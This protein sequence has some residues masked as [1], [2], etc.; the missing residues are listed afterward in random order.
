MPEDGPAAKAGRPPPAAAAQRAALTFWGVRAGIAA[1]GAATAAFG[2]NSPC[3]AVEVFAG[4]EA[5][6][7]VV[8]FDAGTG[9]RPLGARLAPR[10]PVACDLLFGHTGFDRICGLP[11]FAAAFDAANRI[12]CHCAHRPREGG[13]RAALAG[14]MA[15]PL[16]PVPIDV[17]KAAMSF[18]D[19]TPGGRAALFGGAR[20]ASLPLPAAG[21]R[22]SAWRLAVAGASLVHA[23]AVRP[24]EDGERLAA[25]ARGCDLLVIGPLAGGEGGDA[26]AAEIA[27][28]AGAAATV[29]TGHAPEA[30]DDRLLRRE[31]ALR[32]RL[33]SARLA[34][35]GM[36]IALG[37]GRGEP[38]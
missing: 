2:G 29:V 31:E 24:G 23:G 21:P 25:F 7:R 15:D 5:P 32:K 13:I 16:F 8:I 4:G 28:E 17:F 22:G 36:T 11:F 14:L 33:P 12:A 3:A 35:E 27:R 38:A 6:R 19:L 26:A 18:H 34:R 20:A 30:C 37:A 9:L 1:P 10:A